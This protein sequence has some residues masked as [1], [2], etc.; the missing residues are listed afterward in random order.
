MPEHAQGPDPAGG[1]PRSARWARLSRRARFATAGLGAAV[2]VL[3]VALGLLRS[4][5]F[6][7]S[8]PPRR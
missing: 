8:A 2:V 3:G 4:G 5:T 1:Q 6:A 7:A